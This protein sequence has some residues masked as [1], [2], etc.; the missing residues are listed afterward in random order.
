MINLHRAATLV[1]FV[2]SIRQNNWYYPWFKN[3]DEY[4]IALAK[5][6]FTN[7]EY[8]YCY[9]IYKLADIVYRQLYER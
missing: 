1:A 8:Q 4:I 3:A 7:Y 6:D 2:R 9:H 5:N